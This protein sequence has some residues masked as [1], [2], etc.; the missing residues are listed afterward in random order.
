MTALSGAAGG[1]GGGTS[2]RRHSGRREVWRRCWRQRQGPLG[3]WHKTESWKEGR[4][5]AQFFC[6]VLFYTGVKSIYNDAIVSGVQQSGP[7]THTCVSVLF[8]ILFPFRSSQNVEPPSL[9]WTAGPCWLSVLNTAVCTCPPQIP[10]SLC[11]TP[12]LLSASES[13]SLS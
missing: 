7:V 5:F 8:Q 9:R 11:P 2:Q 3:S 1:G 13:A 4:W 12:S 10:V 6:L